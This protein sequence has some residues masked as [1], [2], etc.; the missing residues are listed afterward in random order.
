M[1]TAE[2]EGDYFAMHQRRVA[3]RS[4][5]W[6]IMGD[7]AEAGDKLR[8]LAG[9][10]FQEMQLVGLL[11]IGL[12]GTWL[13]D[14]V[15]C[16]STPGLPPAPLQVIEGNLDEASIMRAEIKAVKARQRGGVVAG[17]PG[18]ERWPGN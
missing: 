14:A 8:E 17:T 5:R 15:Y 2:H 16:P 4:R 12:G 18:S 9:P 10:I 13:G 6:M 3:M 7:Q 1:A 11:L